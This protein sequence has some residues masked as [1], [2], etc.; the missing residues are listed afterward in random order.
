MRGSAGRDATW[1]L[2]ELGNQSAMAVLVALAQRLG[3]RRLSRLIW[4]VSLYYLLTHRTA[5]RGSRAYL[6]RVFGR[7]PTWIESLRHIQAFALV[8]LDRV[9]FLGKPNA[10]PLTRVSGGKAILDA[11]SEGRGCILIGAHI[12]SFE[13]LRAV[14]RDVRIRMRIL[15][16]RAIVGGATRRLEA[17]DPG[18]EDAI[19]PIG[20]PDTMLRVAEALRRN[21]VVGMLG[22]RAPDI[23]RYLQ[24]ELLGGA[25]DLPEGPLR[26]AAVTGAPVVLFRALRLRD[27]TYDVRFEPLGISPDTVTP[28]RAFVDAGLDRY[29]AWME[30]LCRR[31]PFSWFNFYDFW[32]E[33]P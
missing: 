32:K 25:V 15:M 7:S 20:E 31:N 30:N 2:P 24:R 4:P 26:L 11:L 6:R 28:R 18:Y 12:G 16:Y 13:A 9:Y 21:E 29:V 17:L 19:I 23:G 8:I 3:R 27:G 5:R 14:G 33:L 10:A 1:V 22:D